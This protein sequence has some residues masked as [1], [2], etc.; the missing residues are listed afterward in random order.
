MDIDFLV[1]TSAGI[2]SLNNDPYR[3]A[4]ESF[5]TESVTHRRT[6]VT[7]PHV[8]GT[9]IV[10]ALRDNITTPVSVWVTTATRAELIPAVRLLCAAFD[11]VSFTSQLV[12]DGYAQ[13]WNCYASDY[14]VTTS[15]ELM[16]ATRA[17][18]DVELVRDPNESEA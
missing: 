7:N 6:E 8:E 11:Q 10:N 18:V 4:G 9:Y 15:R 13:F 3:L 17:R 12:I 1:S 14:T 2:L 16:H 5:A